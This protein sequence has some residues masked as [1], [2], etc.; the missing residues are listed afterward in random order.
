MRRQR[1]ALTAVPQGYAGARYYGGNEFIDESERLCIARA[2]KAFRLS[3]DRWGVNVQPLSGSPAN[4]ATFNAVLQPHDR[5]MGLALA[6]GG[7]LTHGFMAPTGKR[8]SATSVY[9]ESMPY[10]V[11]PKTGHIDYDGL[12]L[13]ASSFRPKLIIAG[14]SAYSRNYDYKRMRSVCDSVGALLLSDM[15][16]VS[17][18]VAANL[19]N[20]PFEYSDIVTTTTHKTL[21]G[22]RSGLIFFRKGVQRTTASGKE[23]MYD[24]EEKIN[25]SV[26]PGLQGGPH[27][28]T[29]A[30]VS[31]A[32]HESMTPAFVE[33]QKQVLKNSK[34]LAN[35]LMSKG[36]K[37]VSGGTDNHLM[38]VDA[39]GKQL[40]VQI[41][42]FA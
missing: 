19:V 14:A 7:H 39:K 18:L 26:F 31:T 34:H 41:W 10:H 25:A 30:A 11:S 24:L 2:L 8:I 22:P 37:L 5:L 36:Y 13:L 38:L 12:E 4:F 9:W 15:A 3:P 27:E 16:H 1:E 40:S 21:R 35:E 20:D 23:I 6:S 29:I 33:Y 28:H 32:L 17:G 42:Y